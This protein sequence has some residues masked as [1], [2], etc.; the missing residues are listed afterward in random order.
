MDI[1]LL[2]RPEFLGASRNFRPREVDALLIA[3]N[4]CNTFVT[5]SAREKRDC[6]S[7]FAN[8]K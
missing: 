4:E 1:N 7:S 5:M 3:V 2:V 8:S 6:K